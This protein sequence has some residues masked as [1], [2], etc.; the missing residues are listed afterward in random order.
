MTRFPQ[1]DKKFGQ[2]FL[3]SPSVIEAITTDRPTN[4]DVIIEVGPGPA[5]LTPKLKAQGLPLFVFEMDKRFTETLQGVVGADHLILTDALTVNWMDFLQ[6]HNFQNAW[7]VSNLPYNVSVPLTLAFM[8]CP[9]I[10]RMTLM[11]Q[12]EVAEKFHPRSGKNTMS[13]LYA[14]ASI[15]FE[16]SRVVDVPPGAF[17]PPPKVMSQ[18][19]RFDRKTHPLVPLTEWKQLEEF[20]RLVFQNRRKQLQGQLKERIPRLLL[21]NF[22]RDTQIPEGIRAEALTLEQL[23]QLWVL[24]QKQSMV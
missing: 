7:L 17:Q 2:H 11:Y 14:L 13:S 8:Q 10:Q 12:K 18:V 19:L 23:L 20:L 6:R 1:A 5:V 22:F 16:V 4:C 15:F 21:E 3:H 9:H 24:D